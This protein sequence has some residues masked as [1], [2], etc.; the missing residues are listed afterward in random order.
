MI[1]LLKEIRKILVV[2]DTPINFFS[3]VLIKSQYGK[4]LFTCYGV[5]IDVNGRI[6]VKGYEQGFKDVNECWC[7]R[8]ILQEIF[9]RIT[10]DNTGKD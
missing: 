2:I 3:P 10:H 1:D 4:V 6:F 8:L 5:L 9:K 7:S